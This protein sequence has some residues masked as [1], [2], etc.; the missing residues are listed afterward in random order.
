MKLTKS[1]SHLK[2]AL[3]Y[4]PEATQTK[5][6]GYNRFPE[7]YPKFIDRGLGSKVWDADDN[8]YIDWIMGLGPITLGYD[9]IHPQQSGVF[10]LPSPREA[11]LAELLCDIIPCAEMVR[12]GKNGGDATMAAVRLARAVTGRELV[13]Y[14]GYHGC[15]DWYA[16]EIIPNAGTVCQPLHKFQYNNF[17]S[18]DQLRLDNFACAI[19]EIPPEEPMPGFLEWVIDLCHASGAL[20]ILDEI[21]TG[22]RYSLGGAQE[23]YGIT[24][25]LACFGKG[26]ANG[27]PIS[28]IVGK[29]KYMEHFSD[30][31]FSTTFGG[32]I[33]A[34]SASTITINRI[35]SDDVIKHI[36]T[37]G[38]K[39]RSGIQDIIS[40]YNIGA[41]LRGN[42][43]R[44]LIE[45]DDD[46]DFVKKSLFLQEVANMGVLMGVPIFPCASHTMQDVNK[47]IEAID[48]AFY[49]IA[50][51]KDNPREALIGKPLVMTGI[52]K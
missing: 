7:L 9:L 44:S 43:A 4:I 42:P 28:A 10:S 17:N 14:C 16:H 52:R 38:R 23:L 21:V 29:R 34:I 45:F 25:D 8:E 3:R 26:M 39:L 1:N 11:E 33:G 36:W 27:F 37:I 46:P 5:S 35:I 12:F 30:I 48:L 13:A 32:D 51:H 50:Q 22:F 15:M 40:K 31:F 18:L 6:K 47:T 2:R 41:R 49:M 20:F 19:M 24:P